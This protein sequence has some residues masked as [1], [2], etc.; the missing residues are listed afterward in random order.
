VESG[1]KV[2]LRAIDLHPHPDA[3]K[4]TVNIPGWESNPLWYNPS[5]YDA[6]FAVADVSGS[7]GGHPGYQVSAFKQVFGKPSAMYR[8]DG[9]Y[10]LIY[11]TNLLRKLGPVLP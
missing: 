9:W 2:Q 6:T 11:Q 3:P 1:N 10:V 5:A 4:M 8:V 7:V